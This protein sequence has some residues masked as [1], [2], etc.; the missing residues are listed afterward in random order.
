MQKPLCQ[1]ILITQLPHVCNHS[2]FRYKFYSWANSTLCFCFCI[3]KPPKPYHRKLP[4]ALESNWQLQTRH[5]FSA[6]K[7]SIPPLSP[8]CQQKNPPQKK[9]ASHTVLENRLIVCCRRWISQGSKKQKQNI[10]PEGSRAMFCFSRH[11]MM[12]AVAGRPVLSLS[13]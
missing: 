13:F 5:K 1:I 4:V 9:S 2:E 7:H 12:K 10:A 6:L 8:V 3:Y 11:F